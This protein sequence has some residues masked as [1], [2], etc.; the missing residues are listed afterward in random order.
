MLSS[1]IA[2]LTGRAR[3]SRADRLL[4]AACAAR[5]SGD[6]ERAADLLAQAVATEPTRSAVRCLLAEVQLER[7]E[8]LA[9]ESA[10][11][12]V[13]RI[14]P[15]EAQAHALL[16]RALRARGAALEASHSLLRAIELDPGT[17]TARTELAA[18]LTEIGR[19]FEAVPLLRW[20]L[21]RDQE[22]AAAHLYLGVAL[23]EMG[24]PGEALPHFE[25]AAALEP[26]HVGHLNHLAMCLRGLDRH[27]ESLRVLGRALE[28]A[29]GETHTVANLASVLREL[30]RP[31]QALAAITPLAA[32]RPD[33]V[34]VRCVLAAALQDL[35]D[36]DRARAQYDAAL[37][38]EPR[39]GYARLGRGLLR[40]A[41][42]DFERGWDDYEGRYDTGESPK[43]GF[44]FPDW[45]G[46]SLAGRA[47]LVY[48]EQGLGDEIMFASCL[49]DVIEEAGRV[50]VEC[51]PRLAPLFRRSFPRAAVYGAARTWEH[52]WLASAGAI[53]LQVAAGSLPCRY[54][55]NL[56]NFP[57]R[58][59]Y[60]QADAGRVQH[61]HARLAALG[62]GRKIGI[63]WRGGLMRTRQA[64]RSVPPELLGP[65]L[66]RR[67]LRFVSL[68]H[69][70]GEDELARLGGDGGTRVVHWPDVV[71][72]PD[73]AAALMTA[74]DAVLTVCSS[75]V[76][77]GGALGVRVIALVPTRPEWRYLR[78][79]IRIPWYPSVELVRQDRPGEWGSVIGQVA[80]RL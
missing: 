2:R 21:K 18:A 23:Q 77:L 62:P 38:R 57:A 37:A 60:L 9:A 78:E 80:E 26:R 34:G 33:D 7:G 52:E 32:R 67:E 10:M 20:V 47:V 69:D 11:R 16:G 42:G 30:G 25:R 46:R 43:R 58:R 54:R 79:G 41:M 13:I 66:A 53:D 8:H 65:V 14:A 40:L 56:A 4:D 48:A 51:D 55:R 75:V 76:H 28:L 6:S 15:A 27:E 73:E 5:A 24:K 19:P 63:A 44:P 35:G 22:L 45:D 72:V 49:P 39:S 61:Y 68:Q 64:V 17:L 74:L 71:S 3:P 12:D 29:P 50:V 31:E 70:A 36:L 1:L 59:G